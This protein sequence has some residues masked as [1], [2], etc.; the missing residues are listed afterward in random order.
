M[1]MHDE[2]KKQDKK[3][4]WGVRSV[5]IALGVCL[6]A[7][8]AAAWATFGSISSTLSGNVPD[9][10]ESQLAAPTGDTLSGVTETKEDTSVAEQSEDS[11][12]SSKEEQQANTTPET[13]AVPLQN[14]ITKAYSGDMPVYSQTLKDWRTHTGTDFLAEAG[15]TVQSIA[16]G[17]VKTI[18][19][20][21]LLGIV[22]TVSY[23]EIEVSY[24][25]LEAEVSVQEGEAVTAGQAIGIV[26]TVPAEQADGTHL[27]LEIKRDG[28]YLDAETLLSETE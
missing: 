13:F 27:H 23:G 10:A 4:S 24:C 25:G 15:E 7:V 28:V 21:D 14:G 2:H 20:D 6:V 16:D 9:A 1:T 12:V 8:V 19:T 22:V 5:Y 17:T 11:A 26:G 3:G 18:S